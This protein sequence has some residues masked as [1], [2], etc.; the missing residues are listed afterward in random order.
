M[1]EQSKFAGA[2]AI[3]GILKSVPKSKGPARGSIPFAGP[4]KYDMRRRTA[5]GTLSGRSADHAAGDLRTGITGR[6][7]RKIIRLAVK[8]DRS[9][10]D[11]LYGKPVGQKQ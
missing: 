9:A 3:G 11:L 10:N 7:G 4:F 5:C 1:L 6:L 8:D 2:P